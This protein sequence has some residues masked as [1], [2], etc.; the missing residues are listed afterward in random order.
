MVYQERFRL[1]GE[2]AVVTG[3]GRRQSLTP[4]VLTTTA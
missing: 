4:R 1:D 3:G 2:Q